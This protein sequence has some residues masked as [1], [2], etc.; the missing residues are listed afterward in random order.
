MGSYRSIAN[1]SNIFLKKKSTLL[2]FVS[3]TAI[4]SSCSS[5][6]LFED[7]VRVVPKSEHHLVQLQY[8]FEKKE[9]EE[10]KKKRNGANEIKRGELSVSEAPRRGVLP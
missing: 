5:V 3:A 8:A 1:H 2:K 4:E 7:S 6:G 10:G 9:R